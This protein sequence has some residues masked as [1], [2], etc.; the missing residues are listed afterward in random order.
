MLHK[1][2]GSEWEGVSRESYKDEPGTWMQVTRQRLFASENSPFETR[3]FR[4]EAGG[5][6]SFEHHQ[7]EHCVIVL[8]GQGKVRLGEHWHEISARD[9]IHVE[10]NQP[11]QFCAS[12]KQS[13]EIICIVS[14]DRD[15]PVLLGNETAPETS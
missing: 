3:I 15:R 7:H 9:L 1:A 14:R 5:Y 4:I 8:S 6:S 10:P 13:M 2:S 12:S 11:H